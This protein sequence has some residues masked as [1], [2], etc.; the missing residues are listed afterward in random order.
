V[1][2][3]VIASTTGEAVKAYIPPPLPP[4]PP[5][6]LARLHGRIDRANR[7]MGRLDGLSRWASDS[8]RLLYTYI[9]KEAVLSSQIEGT[10]PSLSELLLFENSLAPGGAD[11]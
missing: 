9:R 10:R 7:A 5:M 11:G 3:Y 4:N 6:N 8:N 1:G 2:S